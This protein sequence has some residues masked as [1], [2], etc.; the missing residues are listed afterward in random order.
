MKVRIGFTHDVRECAETTSKASEIIVLR[1]HE[2]KQAISARCGRVE[3]SI[4][5]RVLAQNSRTTGNHVRPTASPLTQECSANVHPPSWPTRNPELF[6]I[7]LVDASN[8]IL[9][10]AS[11]ESSRK[12]GPGRQERRSGIRP[13]FTP[14][15]PFG[16]KRRQ[17]SSRSRN[18]F[19]D[20][21]GV[22]WKV[23]AA[24]EPPEPQAYANP[25]CFYCCDASLCPRSSS[26]LL[27]RPHLAGH[28][29]EHAPCRDAQLDQSAT[30]LAA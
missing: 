8:N 14:P 30:Q 12:L 29:I 5:S 19:L 21:D 18:Y 16:H 10:K 24:D 15:S 9:L 25:C 26:K 13:F 3:D 1:I 17:G 28:E 27:D 2:L 11:A 20:V 22:A 7:L 4:D 6:Q 23:D